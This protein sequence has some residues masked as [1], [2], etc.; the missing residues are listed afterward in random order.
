VF[1]CRQQLVELPR[2][3]NSIQ[4][5]LIP[6]YDTRGTQIY[7]PIRAKNCPPSSLAIF[8][9]RTSFQLRID[10]VSHGELLAWLA[11]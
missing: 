5:L 11:I 6:D 9:G 10:F 8:N 3:V 1:V 7:Q 4:R 2:Q